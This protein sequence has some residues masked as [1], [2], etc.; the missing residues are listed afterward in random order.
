M[1]PAEVAAAF[2]AE[3]VLREHLARP[4]YR[5]GE[6]RR[7]WRLLKIEWPM[8]YFAVAAPARS[9]APDEYSLRIDISRYPDAVTGVFW[10]LSAGVR[11]ADSRWP[12]RSDEGAASN[13]NQ[14]FR[15][16]EFL[17]I[18]PD[19]QALNGHDWAQTRSL[20]AWRQDSD[21]TQYLQYVHSQLNTE[22][23]VGIRSA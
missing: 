10:D 16:G 19:Y 18:P 4:R 23:Y 11:L 17:Y 15:V 6:R 1:Q 21:I 9:G 3:S 5:A 2:K 8:A 20:D 13:C 14:A 7:H 22:R 12:K